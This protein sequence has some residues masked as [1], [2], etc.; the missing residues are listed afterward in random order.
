MYSYNSPRF[1]GNSYYLP[2]TLGDVFT[3]STDITV[4]SLGVFDYRDN[5]LGEA[6]MVGIFDNSG[7]LLASTLVSAGTA[8]PLEDHFRYAAITPL[9]LSAPARLTPLRRYT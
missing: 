4:S 2:Q 5:G 6:H 1:F 3:P 8:N 9:K 7:A